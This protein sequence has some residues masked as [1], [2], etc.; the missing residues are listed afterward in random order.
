[1]KK[2]RRIITFLLA[3]LLV[4]GGLLMKTVIM[5]D[6]GNVKIDTIR[7]NGTNENGEEGIIAARLYVPK[8]ATAQTPAPGILLCPGGNA[9]MEYMD[10]LAIEYARRGYV[11][12]VFDPYTIGRSAVITIGTDAG[13]ISCYNYLC[14][15]EFVNA[16]ATGVGGHSA[17]VGRIKACAVDENGTSKGPLSIMNWSASTEYAYE[18]N[19]NLGFSVATWDTTRKTTP[20]DNVEHIVTAMGLPEGSTYEMGKWYY[21]DEGFGRIAYTA[22][23][24]HLAAL[25]SPTIVSQSM[26]FM[27]ETVPGSNGLDSGNLIY[28]WT[29]VFS[30]LAFIGV[31]LMLFPIGDWLIETRFFS[32]LVRSVPEPA[33]TADAQFFFFLLL[34]GIISGFAAPWMVFNGQNILGK[35]PWLNATNTNGIVFWFV[36]N[37]IL[38]LLILFLRMRFDKR[39]D[40]NRMKSHVSLSFIQILKTLLL[41][42]ILVGVMYLVCMLTENV[43][44]GNVPR[45]WKLQLNTLTPT[46]LGLYLCYIPLYF[47]CNL[48]GGYSQTLG[49]RIKGSHSW[50]FTFLVWFAIS[51]APMIFLGRVY[52][53]MFLGKPTLIQNVQMSR[54][55]GA[56]FAMIYAFLFTPFSTT[57]F[58]KKTGSFYTGA[59]VNSFLLCWI[60]LATELLRV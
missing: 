29:E 18:T 26:D 24:W 27:M 42:F 15:L 28:F 53:T 10:D 54:A 17:G 34:P 25:L 60:A 16:A 45:L 13:T 1:M 23:T 57:H 55:N 4:F 48:V 39:V 12:M 9:Q 7:I 36:F 2:N 3:V 11:T 41:G 38:T 6:F 21:N 31:F 35:L 40:I 59:F 32:T 52:G 8:S 47:F 30:A 14:S 33:T 58:Y 37:S 43:F 19:A 56:M 46:R 50:V 49:L 51:L 5:S 22:D 44:N 20:V